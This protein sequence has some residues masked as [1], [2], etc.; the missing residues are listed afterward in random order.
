[1]MF[2]PENQ[3]FSAACVNKTAEFD[4]SLGKI[5]ASVNRTPDQASG[6]IGG[7]LTPPT[8]A[9]SIMGSRTNI[10]FKGVWH[11]KNVDAPLTRL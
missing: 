4:P 8:R 1:M 11:T 7:D 6:F 3:A 10:S 5:S 2:N 9:L